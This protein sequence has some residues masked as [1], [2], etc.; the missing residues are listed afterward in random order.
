MTTTDF[1]TL[2]D[3]DDSLVFAAINMVVL[4]AD[5][6]APIPEELTENGKLKELGSEWWTAGE[7]EQKS[8]VDL[9]PDMKVEGPE[10]YG[11]RGRRRDFITEK[12]SI[13]TSPRKKPAAAR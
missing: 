7:I 9:A 2:K 8:G 5:Y 13:S 1:Y 12:P 6:G 10:G 11:S 3:K 4:L